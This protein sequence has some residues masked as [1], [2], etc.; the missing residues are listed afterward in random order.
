MKKALRA[1]LHQL[2]SQGLRFKRISVSHGCQD[3]T[4]VYTFV[5]TFICVLCS[6]LLLNMDSHIVIND[7]LD[8]VTRL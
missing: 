4:C 6:G 7:N 8:R 3:I 5:L 2:S 1:S